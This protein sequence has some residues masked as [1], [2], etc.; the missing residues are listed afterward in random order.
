MSRVRFEFLGHIRTLAG[1]RNSV[2]SLTGSDTPLRSVL[3]S[4]EETHENLRL[5]ED[6]RLLE[7]ILVF[8][9]RE[10]GGLERIDDLALPAL[11][12]GKSEEE[13]VIATGMEGG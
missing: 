6:E 2:V 8:R 10:S 12:N 9:R 5:F 7:G 3:R 4:T 13:Y 1:E 11:G